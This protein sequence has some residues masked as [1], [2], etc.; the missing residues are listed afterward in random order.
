MGMFAFRADYVRNAEARIRAIKPPEA[1]VNKKDPSFGKSNFVVP[2]DK[3]G[4]PAPAPAEPPKPKGMTRSKAATAVLD[5][6]E[7][8][9]CPMPEPKTKDEAPKAKRGRAKKSAAS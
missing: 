3:L 4:T 9:N 6:V 5:P 1:A 2:E 8:V 7:P